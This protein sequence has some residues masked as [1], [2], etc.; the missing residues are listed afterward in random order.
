MFG[1][2]VKS[3]KDAAGSVAQKAKG[4]AK[5]ILIIEDMSP[6]TQVQNKNQQIKQ[7]IK[8]NE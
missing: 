4:I 6:P 7:P 3:I 5:D 2:N 8:S 1:W